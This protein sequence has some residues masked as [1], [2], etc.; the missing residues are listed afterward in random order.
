ME[1]KSK[2]GAPG[3]ELKTGIRDVGNVPSVIDIE[4]LR[5][6]G[7]NQ[8]RARFGE[9]EFSRHDEIGG[10]VESGANVHP[11]AYLSD[12]VI[13]TSGSKIGKNAVL[14]AYVSVYGGAVGEGATVPEFT[15]IE[16]NSFYPNQEL[17][18]K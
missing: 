6:V 13:V 10:W 15:K 7:R 2:G 18:K 8:K 14:K 16:V 12:T 9:R 17:G 11:T 3:A 1:F 4:F 5:T